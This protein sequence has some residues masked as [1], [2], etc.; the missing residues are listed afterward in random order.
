MSYILSQ[1]RNT[2]KT[3]VFFDMPRNATVQQDYQLFLSERQAYI[4]MP[5]CFI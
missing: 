4:I 3:L 1:I 2:N 5:K